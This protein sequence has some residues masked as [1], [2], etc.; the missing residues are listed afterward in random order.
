MNHAAP[1][2]SDS[3]SDPNAA[4]VSLPAACSAAHPRIWA[5]AGQGTALNSARLWLQASLWLFFGGLSAV[6]AQTVVNITADNSTWQVPAGVYSLT[7]EAWGGGAGGGGGANQSQS[8]GGGGAY[9][10]RTFTVTPAETLSLDVGSGGNGGT[11]AGNGQNGFDTTVTRN[12]GSLLMVRAKG[13]LVSNARGVSAG[14]A[15]A[16]CLPN[17]TSGGLARSGGAGSAPV[18]N[19][20]GGGGSSATSGS[21]GNS[22]TS[23]TS[24]A[25][26]A[27]L[28]SGA[29]ANG[30][31]NAASAGTAGAPGGGGGGKG[32]GNSVISSRGGDGLIRITYTLAVAPSVAG[33][34][35]SQNYNEGTSGNLLLAPLGTLT[36]S[37]SPNLSGGYLRV[38]IM[39]NGDA[40][41][42]RLWISEI[43]SITLEN[44]LVSSNGVLSGT[45]TVKHGATTIGTIT[46]ANSG[47]NGA[48]L[49][50]DFNASATP[51]MAQDLLRSLYYRNTDAVNAV[52][53]TRT[54]RLT[55]NDANLSVTADTDITV[56]NSPFAVTH[57][58]SAWTPILA[59]NKYDPSEDQQASSGPDLVGGDGIPM[60]YGKY[61]D[62]GT[63]ADFSDDIVAF[64]ARVDDSLTN[65]GLYSG[66]VFIGMDFELDGDIDVFFALEGTSKGT[67]VYVYETS[68]LCTSPST[69]GI[70]AAFLVPNHATATDSHYAPVHMIEG[71][72]LAAANTYSGS[73]GETDYFIS[74]KF[75]FADL[76]SVLD[77][78]P[79]NQ[80]VPNDGSYTTISDLEVDALQ[81]GMS[82]VTPYRFI[83]ATATQNN[84]LNSDFGGIGR[85]SR[86]DATLSWQDLGLFDNEG[87]TFGN[88]APDLTSGSGAT[89]SCTIPENST[90]VATITAADPD[91]DDVTF[92]ILTG[93]SHGADGGLFQ[94]NPFTG[95]LSFIT[96]PNYEIPSD[97]DT[98]NEYLVTVEASDGK[99]GVRTQLV[100]VYVTDEPE[101][102]NALPTITSNGAGLTATLSYAENGT[103]TVTTVTATDAGDLNPGVVPATLS[104]S[105]AGGADATAFAIDPSTGVLT[106][107]A[108][109]DYE[110]QSSYTVQVRVTDFNGATDTQTLT[111]N[112]TNVSEAPVLTAD[113]PTLATITEDET[114]N[115]GLRVKDLLNLNVIDADFGATPAAA[116]DDVG[117]AITGMNG[118]NGTWE[119]STD[120][121]L[122]WA[123][124]DT[125][126]NIVLEEDDFGAITPVYNFVSAG[127]L[128]DSNALLLRPEDYVRFKPDAKNS[129]TASFD[130]LAWDQSSGGPGSHEDA[131]VTGGT[132]AF[133]TVSDTADITVTDVN[134]APTVAGGPLNLPAQMDYV[135]APTDTR[136]SALLADAGLSYGDVDTGAVSGLAV[137]GKSGA[138]T[139]Q[140][141]NGTAWADITGVDDDTAR[142]LLPTYS[143]RYLPAYVGPDGGEIANLTLRG[144]DRT[145]GTAGASGDASPNG[146]TTAYSS[147]SF[148]LRV[149]IGEDD[150]GAAVSN[151]AVNEV[152]PW[153]VFTVTGVAGQKLEFSTVNGSTETMDGAF[154]QYYDG[155]WQDYTR[156]SFVTLAGATLLVRV[157]IS[158]E[159]DAESEGSETYTLVATTTGG[160]ASTGGAGTIT[161]DGTGH[162][163]FDTNATATPNAPAEPGYPALDDDRVLLVDDPFTS[164]T[165][166]H[167]V[168]DVL[169]ATDQQVKLTLQPYAGPGGAADISGFSIWIKTGVDGLGAPILEAY[170]AGSFVPL[171]AAPGLPTTGLMEVFVDISSEAEELLEGHECFLLK[172]ETTSGTFH[173][174]TGSIYDDGSVP[175]G[176]DD[177]PITMSDVTVNE[178]SKY[179]VFTATGRELQYV[180]FLIDTDVLHDPLTPEVE[181]F[182]LEYRVWNSTLSQWQWLPYNLDA[183]TPI[184][185]QFP[186]N[187]D[188][189]LDEVATLLV[190]VNIESEWDSE[191]EGR[192]VFHLK[193]YTTSAVVRYGHGTIVDDGT[194]DIFLE[195][196][197]MATPN[198]PTDLGYP[199]LDDERVPLV[200]APEVNEASDYAIFR[201][202]GKAGQL[203]ELELGLDAEALTKNA[204]LT[205]FTLTYWDGDSWEPYTAGD[206][207]TVPAGDVLLV[208]VDIT[209]EQDDENE[210]REV[211]TLTAATISGTTGTGAG[212]IF[213]DGSGGVFLADNVTGNPSSHLHPLYPA[214]DDDRAASLSDV[215]VNEASPW[216]VFTV[217]AVSGQRLSFSVVDVTT[218]GMNGAELEYL[219]GGAWQPY[220]ANSFVILA[221]ATQLV[222]VSIDPEQDTDDEGTQSYRL[223]ATTT[224]GIVSTGGVGSI[225]DDG[226]GD[227]FMDG[228]LTS[229]PDDPSASG[230]PA[231]D[232]DNF[233]V[234]KWG[235][236]G[237]LASEGL[238]DVSLIPANTGTPLI[239]SG[240]D[241]GRLDLHVTTQAFLSCGLSMLGGEVSV[242]QGPSGS[243]ALTRFRFYDPG[244]AAP[245][246]IRNIYFSL[247]DAELGE[248]LSNFAYWDAAGNRVEL[249]WDSPVFSYSH[250]PVFINSARA[251]ENGAPL[252][253]KTQA[254]KWIRVDLRG[255]AV[256]GIEYGFRKSSPSAGSV[257]LTHLTGETGKHGLELA[258]SEGISPEVVKADANDE[259]SMPD[260][261]TQLTWDLA[262]TGPGAVVT[263][264]PAPGTR[265]GLGDHDVRMTLTTLDGQTATLGFCMTVRP[266]IK[267]ALLVTTP[268]VSTTSLATFAPYTVR[269]TVRDAENVGIDR[270]VVVH[271]GVSHSALLQ[272][273]SASGVTDWSLEIMPQNGL[274]TLAVTAFDADEVSSTTVV[275]SFQ[276]SRRYA[277]DM[278]VA[279]AAGTVAIQT[280][281]GGAFNL[282]SV[283]GATRTYAVQPGSVITFTARPGRGA[284]FSHW[285]GVPEEGVDV[286]QGGVETGTQLV[287]QMPALDVLGIHAHFVSSPFTAPVGKGTTFYGLLDPVAA[288]DTGVL[289]VGGLA[290]NL[291]ATGGFS[292]T[293]T[294]AGEVSRFGGVFYGRGNALFTLSRSETATSL[295]LSNGRVLELAFNVADGTITA[296]LTRSGVVSTATLQRA[297]YSAANKVPA[298]LLNRKTRAT[299]PVNNQGFYTAALPSVVQTTGIQLSGYPQGSGYATVT[300]ADVG[301]LMMVGTLADGTTFTAST[302]LVAG[303]VAPAFARLKTPGAS[304]QLGSLG[305]HLNFAVGANSDVSSADL[306][307]IRPAVTQLSGTT[308][309]AKATQLYTAGWPSGIAV[310]LA[311]ALYDINLDA[312]TLLNV[313]AAD[314]VA[315]NAELLFHDGKLVGE[316]TLQNFNI[317]GNAVAKIPT[318]DR[319]YTL[320]LS[321]RTAS[322][323][324]SFTPNW[325]N[326][327][328]AK[329]TY[330]GILV[331]KGFSG[332]AGYGFFLSNRSADL[333]PES[334]AV[335]LGAQDVSVPD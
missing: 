305:G 189:T 283:S 147:G 200:N 16:D 335:T 135:A 58:S 37:D 40:T 244:T 143:L 236:A 231:L 164:E 240:V 299:L 291:T 241:R 88:A 334:G 98:N 213:D 69:T 254:G 47:F 17:D 220:S 128:S 234:V 112:I 325:T 271:N 38:E 15:A 211:F 8:G 23:S 232:D 72:T 34:P 97:A 222:R 41:E 22:A 197:L 278:T 206:F 277:L 76:K 152:S 247:E 194:G 210:G 293:L 165:S 64:R 95:A 313:P 195:S 198:L 178:V 96:A 129:T 43:N 275:R 7:V 204:E 6:Q 233:H 321:P 324:G 5:L 138:G 35:A 218:A 117:I 62:L 272:S 281:S 331:Q 27:G 310:G 296:T 20:G 111:V 274:N 52:A 163:F 172:A 87:M 217:T 53:N 11:A 229:S 85:L 82:A 68:N 228:N 89:A 145:T 100:Y 146:G 208:R 290:L 166:Q 148:L 136:V 192:E 170:T 48:P 26:S 2:P 39:S 269:G 50:I 1:T 79:L 289:A 242:A 99:G 93:G 209:D 31:A 49:Q 46:A 133:S 157:S 59:G 215:E 102:S 109:P 225:R 155:G 196:N 250:Q 317:V 205:G 176:A 314:A 159:Q 212:A 303:D 119:Y 149:E 168:F 261:T 262:S 124:F 300:L 328:T 4:R 322:F 238:I 327:V 190:R 90:P 42:D 285:S 24:G 60:L 307:W 70:G 323:S 270:V 249:N 44:N 276:F 13:G 251:V 246:A 84:A 123:P 103:G 237:S 29:G 33:V 151:V 224:S 75:N 140:F 185:V 319:S 141:H 227:V 329:P 207:V 203:L 301:T 286:P 245:H 177:R 28:D 153:A 267:P 77:P 320:T 282:S 25:S 74:F 311:G 260:Y 19:A 86:T 162:V 158:P 101:G 294:N 308:A 239:Y 315:G 316:L 199:V 312:A 266:A 179:M 9:T 118:G 131:S 214:L 66:Y 139:W 187:G 330:K 130:F 221:T 243:V 173:V 306:R 280:T 253:S 309:T 263:Q 115:T 45:T 3:S 326:R 73:D 279:G 297:A 116:A 235:G 273:P 201:V 57:P 14:G 230:Y 126:I 125:E 94:I 122:N 110:T 184:F 174:G 169:G 142:L 284:V 223:V 113:T 288:E 78:R 12:T 92:N 191:Y 156:T 104:Y 18:G 248:Q 302:G 252:V 181:D 268:A 180:R 127:A 154:I 144:W 21:D 91:G 81:V 287:G 56:I 10:Q 120:G 51:A 182:T 80:A 65:T 318:T 202:T 108:A 219:V 226:Q 105:S 54:L 134:D 265:I 175:G 114:S 150:R 61:D 186:S 55:A 258:S 106:F 304:S 63:P 83:L 67:R 71:T 256:T 132:T 188:A 298:D 107:V 333:D 121:G 137:T 160:V 295:S 36:D 255:V 32:N 257:I 332:P 167:I 292:G 264:I 161:D 183:P 171:P 193:P 30:G 216:A 259:A